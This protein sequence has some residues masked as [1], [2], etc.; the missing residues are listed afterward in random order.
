[1]NS[2]HKFIPV[3]IIFIFSSC[4]YLLEDNDIKIEDQVNEWGELGSD[5]Y[6]DRDVLFLSNLIENS[7]GFSIPPPR[8][9]NPLSLGDQIWVDGRLRSFSHTGG[10]GG[11]WLYGAIPTSI[12]DVTYLNKLII[13]ENF[14]TSIPTEIE[15]LEFLTEIILSDNRF[16]GDVPKGLWENKPEL[17]NLSIHNNDFSSITDDV[18]QVYS[19]IPNFVITHNS[20]CDIP[21]CIDNPGL[22][23]C[24]CFEHINLEICMVSNSNI[25][26]TETL[27]SI[28]DNC[29]LKNF[30]GD[31]LYNYL[32]D[33]NGNTCVKWNGTCAEEEYISF[34]DT[35]NQELPNILYDIDLTDDCID[36][37]GNPCN[38]NLVW[39]GDGVCD[40]SINTN[41]S[42][43]KFNCDMEDCG[44]YL[45]SIDE[46]YCQR[47][48]FG[49]C[50]NNTDCIGGTYDCCI[51]DGTCE[52]VDFDGQI[53]DWIG[54]GYCDDGTWGYGFNCLEVDG[55]Q[56]NCDDGDCGYWNEETGQCEFPDGQVNLNKNRNNYL[57]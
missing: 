10:V 35:T 52:D 2:Q 31:T 25:D 55:F 27:N 44:F 40:E 33:L 42:C 13:K 51:D 54:D 11:F 8:D 45:N 7:Q 26:C 36:C 50:I 12:K 18:C 3:L 9:L 4:S 37:D 1:M 46:C 5:G 43:P 16:I 32:L 57:K 21:T 49:N 56:F 29:P 53:V 38:E 47:D 39:I 24:D 15:Q 48:C 22:Q 19:Q 34:S 6:D 20:I 17:I 28:I 14:F 23:S 41:F 30:W